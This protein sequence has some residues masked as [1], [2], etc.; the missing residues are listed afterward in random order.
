MKSSA[1]KNVANPSLYAKAKAKAKAKFDVYP[2]A[3]ANA[4]MVKEY[5]KMGGTYKTPE[6]NEQGRRGFYETKRLWCCYGI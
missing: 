3:Y 1:P 2:S 6:E 4:Y 5:K